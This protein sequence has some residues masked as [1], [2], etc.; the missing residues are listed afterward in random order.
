MRLEEITKQS[1]K[2]LRTHVIDKALFGVRDKA[3]VFVSWADLAKAKL[4]RSYNGTVEFIAKYIVPAMG[5]YVHEFE[6]VMSYKEMKHAY[7]NAFRVEIKKP[8]WYIFNPR[9]GVY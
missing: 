9:Y 1:F 3:I 5:V 6:Q 2:E 7:D 8:F 4:E